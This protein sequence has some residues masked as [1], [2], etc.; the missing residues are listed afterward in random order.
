M[1][2]D[3][4]HVEAFVAFAPWVAF[5]RI[6]KG[7]SLGVPSAPPSLTPTQRLVLWRSQPGSE[8]QC[9]RH[10]RQDRQHFSRHCGDVSVFPALGS[11]TQGKLGGQRGHLRLNGQASRGHTRYATHISFI[12]HQF[13]YDFACRCMSMCEGCAS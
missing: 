3:A 10:V 8:R 1:V 13:V 6:L 7:L 12:C 9:G 5:G 2:S 4:G 11:R